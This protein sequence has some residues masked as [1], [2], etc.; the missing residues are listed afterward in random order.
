MKQTTTRLA[1]SGLLATG[2]FVSAAG[3][4][5][6]QATP[7]NTAKQLFACYV[8]ATGTVYL[9]KQ[10]GLRSECASGHV[11]FSW[12]V[13]GTAPAWRPV[14]GIADPRGRAPTATLGAGAIPVTG[15]G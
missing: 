1:L 10:A 2:L 9:I 5:Q 3:N 13:G 4:L 15:P 7:P 11:Q 8:P 6:A 12:S 14:G